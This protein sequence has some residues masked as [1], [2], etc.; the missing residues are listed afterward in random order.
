MVIADTVCMYVPPDA[1]KYLEMPVH[2]LKP[3]MF[4]AYLEIPWLESNFA[5]QGFYVHTDDDI[6]E[7]ADQCA[8]V[9]VDQRKH[10][11]GAYDTKAAFKPRAKNQRVTVGLRDEIEVAASDY[12]SAARAVGA[13]FD[14]L[15]DIGHIDMQQMA[16]AINPLLDHVVQRKDAMLA[17]LRMRKKDDYLYNHAIAV[18]IWSAMLGQQI[19]LPTHQLRDLT[20][21][22]AL[23]DVG[24]VKLPTDLLT[25]P[26]PLDSLQAKQMQKHVNFSV[27][28]L[29]RD[30][31]LD[32][33]IEGII[34]GHHERWDGSGYPNGASG[35]D[36][37]LGARIA[38]LADTYDAMITE[39]PY[40]KPVSSQEAIMQLHAQGDK[41]FPS[42]LVEQFIQAVG[43]FPV[44]A[45]VELS[46]GDVGVVVAQNPGRRLTPRLALVL[47]KKKARRS[48]VVIIDLAKY[49]GSGSKPFVF[50]KKELADGAFGV[51][52]NSLHL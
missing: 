11:K 12:D 5:I 25:K 20:L 22:A 17:L 50:I 38:G 19:G 46:T 7:I 47:D 32:P 6:A 21:G 15:K 3:G 52:I 30:Q 10:L 26:G 14:R 45:L 4:V 16:D 18:S 24:K 8:Y 34:R 28:M 27:G 23:I 41:H 40:A 43:V 13:A 42:V 2:Q 36:I 48:K 9:F 37:P 35:Q 44:G 33:Y 51:E 31:E 39:R 29:S 1:D 49:D